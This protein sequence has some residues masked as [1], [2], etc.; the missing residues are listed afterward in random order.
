MKDTRTLVGDE[1][2]DHVSTLVE[3][4]FAR[5][6]TIRSGAETLLAEDSLR[7][8]DLARLRPEVVGALG[9]LVNGAGFIAAPNLL[10]DQELGFQWWTLTP[11]EEP[12]QLLISLDPASEHFLDYTRQPWFTIPR[13]TAQRHITGPYVDYLCSDEYALTFTVPLNVRQGF[14]GVV[15]ADVFVKDFERAVFPHLRDLRGRAAL[16][17]SQGRFIVSNNVGQATG[18]LA[19]ELDVPAWWNAGA[20]PRAENGVVLRRCGE[21]PIALVVDRTGSAAS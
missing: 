21:T 3:D 9:E 4:V 16:V 12:A 18:A 20:I 15:G 19:R 1:V 17:N 7:A 8:R 14:A 5:L 10:V 2:I 6:A 13:D 11:G